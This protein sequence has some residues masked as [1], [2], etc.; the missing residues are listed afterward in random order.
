MIAQVVLIP[1]SKY[2][3]LVAMLKSSYRNGYEVLISQNALEMKK[4]MVK[5]Q[6]YKLEDML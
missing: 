6:A 2:D 1:K 3:R 4:K 5:K